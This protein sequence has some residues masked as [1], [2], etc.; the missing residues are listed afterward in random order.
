M[1]DH[2]KTLLSLFKTDA[3]GR[4]DMLEATD[5]EILFV[6]VYDFELHDNISNLIG[7]SSTSSTFE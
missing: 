3:L 6:C 7:G 5:E 1:F 2:N 4:S